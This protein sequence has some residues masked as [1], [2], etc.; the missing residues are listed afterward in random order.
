MDPEKEIRETEQRINNP[1]T[2]Q[3]IAVT[4][5]PD[6]DPWFKTGEFGVDEADEKSQQSRLLAVITGLVDDAATVHKTNNCEAD[7]TLKA[8]K[9]NSVTRL[10]TNE[11]LFYTK[12]PLT[13]SEFTQLQSDIALLA[14]K[15]P[16]NLHLVLSS[17]A[18]RT[19]DNKV[20]NVVMQVQCGKNPHL[21]F[22]V[23]NNPSDRDPSYSEPGDDG[24]IKVL[25]N[26]DIKK[27]KLEKGFTF[28]NVFECQTAGGAKFFSCID[29]CLD[30]NEAVA[31]KNLDGI[32]Q[33]A[34]QQSD[35][36]KQS[37]LLSRN[38]SHVVTSNSTS[39]DPG[40][41]VGTVMQADPSASKRD[42]V[43]AE[44]R[45]KKLPQK[46]LEAPPFGTPLTMY[47]MPAKRC[48]QLPAPQMELVQRN[49]A[50][51][52]KTATMATLKSVTDEINNFKK[53]EELRNKGPE[54][55]GKSAYKT[56]FGF[57][58]SN[59]YDTNAGQL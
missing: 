33:T 2:I 36:G 13:L 7:N 54:S 57:V 58:S 59:L 14:A 5:S 24:K 10:I 16:E 9:E 40:N 41:C 42:A 30:N 11:F 56:F 43:I 15:Q 29:I 49:N 23:K 22:T 17:F 21:Q 34:A 37:D 51:V 25:P 32:L 47:T 27:D 55:S 1:V 31:K 45:N 50:N 38:V 35:K 44:R 26:V 19:S 3:D 52:I 46:E 6:D 18:V 48:D 12:K 8:G 53:Q 39:V 28:N 20:M 4:C